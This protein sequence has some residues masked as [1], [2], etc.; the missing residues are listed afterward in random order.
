MTPVRLAPLLTVVAAV[1]GLTGALAPPAASAAPAAPAQAEE[2]WRLSGDLAAHDPALVAGGGGQDWYV[3]A[4]GEEGKGDGN[5]QIRSSADGHKWTYEGTVWDEIPQWIKDAV[6]GVKNIWAP[7]VYEA[8]G[9]YYMYYSASTWG[10]NR[11]VIGLATNET[12]D[13]SDPAYEWVDRGEV[14]GSEPDDDFNAIDPGVIEDGSGTPYMAFGSYWSGIRMVKLD[15]PSGKLADPDKEPLHIAD[16]K[17]SPNAIEAAYIVKNDGFYY[18]FTSWGQCCQG[19]D[20]DYKMM[21]GRSKKVTGPYVDRDGRKLLDGGGTTLL[22]TSGDRVGP[23]GQSASE[24]IIAY[25][26]YDKSA[27]GATKLA[28]QPIAWDDDGW[29]VLTNKA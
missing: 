3:F 5:V 19:S 24:E 10:K 8:N 28:L 2:P 12:L 7:E 6:P 4:T 21:V 22:T 20:S 27:D 1:V 16:R 9:M 23:G 13:P 17:A 11:S 26:Y 14:I 15:W 25:H 18:L 29:P